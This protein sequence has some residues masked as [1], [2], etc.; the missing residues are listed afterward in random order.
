LGLSDL[1][2][3]FKGDVV[4]AGVLLQTDFDAATKDLCEHLAEIVRHVLHVELQRD[5]IV[6]AQAAEQL[7]RIGGN[8]FE[9]FLVVAHEGPIALLQS[10][11]RLAGRSLDFHHP[12]GLLSAQ[13]R[14]QR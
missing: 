3:E 10:V 14:K 8:R 13:L 11:G 12:I 1:L 5:G 4:F 9:H 7:L 6:L 2:A